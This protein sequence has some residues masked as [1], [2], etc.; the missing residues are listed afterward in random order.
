L[1]IKSDKV[2]VQI[3]YKDTDK[4]LE[5]TAEEVWF[6]VGKFFNEFIPSYELANSLWLNVNLASLVQDCSGLIAFSNE[7]TNVLVPKNKLTDS[8]TLTLWLLG[9][10]IG[11]KLNLLSSDVLSKEELQEKIAKSSKITSTRLGELT[12]SNWVVK[13]ESDMYRITTFG[14]TQMQKEVLPRIKTKIASN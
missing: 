14:V 13:T 6:L 10:Y 5:G 9:A 1:S 12:K 2:Y 7:G 8:E 3:K 4:L 11:N